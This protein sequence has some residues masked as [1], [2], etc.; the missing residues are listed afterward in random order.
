MGRNIFLL[1]GW[2][3]E[4]QNSKTEESK[5]FLQKIDIVIK[6]FRR[7]KLKKRLKKIET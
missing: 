1:G 7:S 2:K 4:F 3:V 5:L 6:F